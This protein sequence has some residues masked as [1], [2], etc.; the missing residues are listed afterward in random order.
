MAPRQGPLAELGN[1][2]PATAEIFQM[3]PRDRR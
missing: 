2:N 1:V 3:P